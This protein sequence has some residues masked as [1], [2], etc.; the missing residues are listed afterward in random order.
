MRFWFWSC[1]LFGVVGSIYYLWFTEL[2]LGVP[3]EWEWHRVPPEPDSWWNLAAVGVTAGFYLAFVEAGAK[4]LIRGGSHPNVRLKTA[5]WLAGLVAAAFT[6]IWV[7]QEFAPMRCRIGK[8]AFVLY[9]PASSGYF[10]KVRY[11]SPDPIPF[12]AGYENLMR[13]GE[14]LHVGTHPP[15]LFLLFHGLFAICDIPPIAT[16]LDATEAESFREAATYVATNSARSSMPLLPADRRVLWMAT[17]LVMSCAS[18]AV[19]PL[20][21]LIARTQTAATAWRA[22]ALWPAVPTVAIFSPKSDAAYAFVGLLMV[23]TWLGA[24]DRRSFVLAFV[25]GLVVWV[26]LMMSLAF[27]PIVLFMVIA[28]WR[29]PPAPGADAGAA[30]IVGRIKSFWKRG[31]SLEC[32]A[33]GFGGVLVPTTILAFAFEIDMITVWWLNYRNHSNF[34]LQFP[35]TYWKWLLENP[36]ELMFS[37]G[38]PLLLLAICSVVSAVRSR[39]I[40]DPP[41]VAG[42]LLVWGTLWLTGKNSSEAARLWIIFIPWLVWLAGLQLGKL[43]AESSPRWFNPFAVILALQLIVGALTVAR[44]SG[45][46]H[47]QR[48]VHYVRRPVKVSLPDEGV[49]GAPARWPGRHGI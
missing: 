18:L 12:L 15:G 45:F 13:Q 48:D 11:K 4:W 37:A 7:V 49:A 41:V 35:R 40:F 27:L 31:P 24:V 1:L 17:L 44:I 2:P 25:S 10:T 3:Y 20:F 6:W 23:I 34:Y 47:P 46:G 42:V 29:P 8:G 14:V 19:V 33:G 43:N 22:A 39:R 32:I 5:A 28:G 36:V 9:Y 16:I 30:G 21:G 26:G 38:W